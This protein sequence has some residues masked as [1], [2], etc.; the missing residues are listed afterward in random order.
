M[1]SLRYIHTADL[2]L[3]APFL[4]LAQALRTGLLAEQLRGAAFTALDR[5]C[6]LCERE[7]PDFLVI[8]GDVYNEENRS[9][10]A[11]LALR[12]ACKRLCPLPVF[13]VHGN[14]DP[15]SSR[16]TAVRWPDNVFIFGPQPSVR[17]VER[18]GE[19]LALV[20]GVSHERAEEPQN[21]SRLLARD[22]EQND[23][24]QLGLLHACLDSQAARNY[25]PCSL[26]DLRESGLDAW[27]L[28]HIHKWGVL[29][30]Q[31]FVAYSG[32][33]QGLHINETGPH[34]CLSV[35]ARY[36]GT[37]WVCEHAFHAL[38]PVVWE[39]V[40]CDLEDAD[41]LDEADERVSAALLAALEQT[42]PCCEALVARLVLKGRTRLDSLLRRSLED[43][44]GRFQRIADGR[45]WI[46]DICC[47]TLP[48][49]EENV[50]RDDI[51]GEVLRCIAEMEAD[52]DSMRNFAATALA[53]LYGNKRLS[54]TAAISEDEDL[55][56]LLRQAGA[57][58]VGR[59]LLDPAP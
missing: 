41:R 22:R 59:L 37:S 33:I 56:H 57:E 38:A 51:L 58:C 11:Q 42:P 2:H 19:L 10:K 20:H 35:T 49:D 31:P 28:G 45:L 5:L 25:A 7:K 3:G 46:K 16:F 39:N 54:E 13:L 32:S 52:P 44:G 23:C 4:G 30:K 40:N 1:P 17:S 36:D 27:A 6:A 21:L 14:H 48:P 50:D 34:G 24:F 53:P 29:S 15:L 43:L 26:A 9:V 8:A 55:K 12:D 47:L 18:D